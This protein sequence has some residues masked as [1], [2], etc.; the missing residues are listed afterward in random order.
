VAFN[1]PL[2][3]ET[4]EQL[5]AA[6]YEIEQYANRLQV[7]TI[8]QAVGQAPAQDTSS[9]MPAAQAI[10]VAWQGKKTVSAASLT[11]LLATLKGLQPPV[12]HLTL[13][14]IAP[15]TLRRALSQWVRAN[16]HPQALLQL[17]VDSSIGGGVVIRT[18]N[19]L[20]D[21]SFR[22]QLLAHRDNLT[23]VIADVR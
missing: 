11:E 15:P 9:L 6:K 8:R 10:I 7:A 16:A 21:D 20:Y 3:L 4:V 19:H 23:K 22:T 5:Q 14:N 1:L 12:L 13:T 18:T 2:E 17:S